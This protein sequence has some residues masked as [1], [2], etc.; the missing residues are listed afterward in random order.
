MD[1]QPH[2]GRQVSHFH[3]VDVNGIEAVFSN[4]LKYRYRLSVPFINETARTKI[5]T[6]ILKNPSS[7]DAMKADKTVQNVEKVI[8]KTF[9]DV[10]KIEVLN[11]FALRGTRPKDVMQTYMA[12]ADIVGSD[13]NTAFK[14]ALDQSDYIVIAWGGASP[15][16]SSLYDARIDDV[17]S[18]IDRQKFTN[19]IFRKKEKGSDKYPFHACYWPDNKDFSEYLF[20][21]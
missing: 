5:I 7:A 15:I 3:R 11:L 20:L 10:R 8:Y 14:Q 21:H 18:M 6:V 4:D 16:R 9:S 19:M 12:G 1:Q 13:N 2:I 17:M